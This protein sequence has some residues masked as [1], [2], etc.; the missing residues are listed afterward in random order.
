MYF[1]LCSYAVS[2][3][4]LMAFM[5]DTNNTKD[6]E[7]FSY[8]SFIYTFSD[9]IHFNILYTLKLAWNS[10]FRVPFLILCFAYMKCYIFDKL[11][12]L[13]IFILNVL[14]VFPRF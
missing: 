14:P 12:F 13:Y 7:L 1:F 2:V 10:L 9:M 6:I 11:I 4:G 8:F 5:P 3:T